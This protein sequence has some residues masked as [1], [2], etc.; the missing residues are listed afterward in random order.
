MIQVAKRNWGY[1]KTEWILVIRTTHR[2]GD[3]IDYR[4][5]CHPELTPIQTIGK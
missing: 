5:D 1:E 4:D 3:H 2:G